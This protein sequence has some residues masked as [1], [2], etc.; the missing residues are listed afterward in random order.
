MSTPAENKQVVLRMWEALYR[1]D[2]DA[3]AACLADD[4]H[5]EDVPAPDPGA[6]GPANTVKRLRIGLDHVQRF[7]HHHHRMVAEGD[8]VLFEHTEIWHFPTGEKLVNHFVTIHEV[9]DG[10]IQLWRDYWDLNTLM[11][12]APAWWI[13]RLAKHDAS[14]WQA[15]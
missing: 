6:D 9:R 10:K 7:E 15:P 3:L 11:S 1:K 2:W 14:E 5:Y 4:C 8:S 13:E 12:Q